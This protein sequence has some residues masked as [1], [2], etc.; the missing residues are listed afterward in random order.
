MEESK[1]DAENTV[2]R[3]IEEELGEKD[4]NLTSPSVGD[5]NHTFIVDEDYVVKLEKNED[6]TS[7]WQEE[8]FRETAVLKILQENE[9]LQIPKVIKTGRI[10]GRYY[11]IIEYLDGEHLDKYSKGRNFHEL[12]RE[13]KLELSRKMGRKLGELHSSKVFDRVGIIEAKENEITLSDDSWSSGIESLQSWWL[14]KL[15]EYGFEE[16]ADRI[17]EVFDQ[18]SET[19]DEVKE[20]TLLHMEFGLRNL[21]F[22]EDDIVILD[23]ET[24]AA[25]D[26]M[27]DL[28]MSQKRI[29]WLSEEDEE[30][31][32]SFR[33]GYKEVRDIQIREKREQLYELFQ[34]TRFLV[35]FS[36]GPENTE[37]RIISRI[38]NLIDNLSKRNKI[39]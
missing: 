35:I 23:W 20:S 28:I 1:N 25:G 33:K 31:Q 10:E 3:L 14:E 11:R 24:C 27:L 21:L 34:M 15:Q 19:L 5:A 22:Q 37:D 32:K 16:T 39:G 29:F 9:T 2:R 18:H 12:E 26:P 8:M 17:G 6:W 30:F 36:G 38:Q 7:G 4:F 13:N